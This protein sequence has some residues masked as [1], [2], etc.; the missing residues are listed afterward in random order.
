MLRARLLRIVDHLQR[1]FGRFKLDAHFLD[2]RGLLLELGCESLC[3]LF[4]LG[5]E[6]LY[7]FLLLGDLLLLLRSRCLL[8]SQLCH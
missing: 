8:T 7:L 1:R 5:C 2:L 3:L 6:S 4:E